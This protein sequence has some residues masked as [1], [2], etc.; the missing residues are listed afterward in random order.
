M[1]HNLFRGVGG[2]D[3]TYIE[4][5][6]SLIEK[7]STITSE[8]VYSNALTVLSHDSDGSI[9]KLLETIVEWEKGHPPKDEYDG[10]SWSMVFGD[11]RTLNS[12]VVRR[13][14]KVVF[15]SNK[16]CAYRT[17]DVRAIEKAL[18]DF[19]GSF[20]Q[21]VVEEA[22][23]DLFKTIIGHPDKL[24]I[25]FRSLKAERPVHC[26]LWGS[27]SS[28]K[29]LILEELSRLPRSRFILGSALSKAGVFDILFNDRPKYL[30]LDEI[31]KID[32]AQNLSALLSLM[33]RGIVSESK[34]R[35]HRTIRLKTWVMAAANDISRLPR[36]FLSRFL[37]LRFK[38]Y[39]DN[40]FQEVTVS[41]LTEREGISENLAIYIAQK[42]L[43]ELGSRDVRDS[44]KV[45][46]LLTERSKAE[47]DK[48]ISIL[49][50]QK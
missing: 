39:S 28:A 41:V 38:D 13:I 4:L 27:P 31:D 17:I 29:S 25:L 48:I 16:F 30:I 19:E 40:E 18:A 23:L 21:E 34:Y 35:R 24:E 46:R 22:P 43:T 3:R 47:V 7:M 11:S 20:V 49:K 37:L 5:F 6:S 44:C 10:F 9:K 12:L 26:L 50:K 2:S 14:L 42:I 1:L 36:E 33:E 8:E 15:K 45:A 32:D